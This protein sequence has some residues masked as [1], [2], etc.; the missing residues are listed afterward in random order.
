MHQK[1]R[2][3]SVLLIV[4]IV[5]AS[6]AVL[7]ASAILVRSM[8]TTTYPVATPAPTATLTP[9][10]KPTPTPTP[11][12][13]PTPEAT[14]APLVPT[15]AP[16]GYFDDALF[17][18]DSR[19]VGLDISGCLPQPKYFASIGLGITFAAYSSA[20]VSGIGSIT[21][22]SLLQNFQFGKIYVMLGINEIGGAHDSLSIVYKELLDKIRSYQPDAIIYI[23][24]NMHVS[25]SYDANGTAVNNENINKLNSLIE[26][27]AD[28]ENIFY[29]DENILFDDA[30]GKLSM[31]YTADGLHLN[32]EAYSALAEW[33]WNNAIVKPAEPAEEEA[34]EEA[35]EA[36][37]EISDESSEKTVDIPEI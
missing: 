37:E 34:G 18:G 28:G 22:P 35:G 30:N 8:L 9:T 19:T 17:I 5:I 13:T 4:L 3:H 25:N 24:A 12:P 33:L 36:S 15:K 1:K 32:T 6:I 2:D 10:P 31:D 21:L 27:Y 11:R 7:A 20:E 26:A 23:M 16:E 29:L 14:P